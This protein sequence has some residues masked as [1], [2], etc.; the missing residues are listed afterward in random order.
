[1]ADQLRVGIL[2]TGNIAPAYV[3]H[4][5]Q[6][7]ILDVV[8]CA[9]L[10]EGRA[11]T[12]AQ[13]HGLQALSVDAM[14]ASPDIDAIINLTIP[15]AHIEV[16]RRIIEA[17]KHVY[18]EKPL[19]IDRDGARELLALAQSKGLRVGCAPDTF[20]GGGL[21][22][23]RKVID[24][25]L[26]GQPIAATAYMMS[27]GP[28]AWHP[29]PFFFYEKGGGP[30]LDMGPYYVT[31]LVHLLGPVQRVTGSARRTFNERVAGHASIAGARVPVSINTHFNGSLEFASGAIAN[32]TMSFDVWRHGHSWIEVY[33]TEG[34]ML[35]PDPN[36]F[37]G[38]VK[39]YRPQESDWR[40]V[41]LTHPADI[42]RGT[43]LADMAYAIQS[44]RPHRASGELAYHVLDTMLAVEEAADAGQHITLTS[45]TPQPAAIPV[46]AFPDVLAG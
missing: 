22:T 36:T 13:A 17:G 43:G 14:L 4:S 27:H 10:D 16:S 12:F 25:G 46:G 18:S 5:R 35:V 19:G 44:G 41:P 38:V 40:E 21:Q 37:G 23:C 7:A 11:Q 15:K 28:E 31:A 2:G 6:Y 20:L 33:G 8:A 26:I 42:G 1:M 29:N 24:D 9:D 30:M 39:I 45:Q 34:S 32:V 3:K